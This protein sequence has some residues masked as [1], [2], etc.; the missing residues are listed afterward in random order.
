[1]STISGVIRQE[2]ICYAG[3]Y[4]RDY[5]RNR[6]V[7]AALRAAG[8]R[9]EEVHAPVFERQRDK[10]RPGPFALAAVLARLVL[11]Y[12]RLVPRTAWRLRRCNA[13]MVGYIGQS[14]ML[15]LAPVA[16]LLRR[17]VIFNPLVTLTDTLVEDRERLAPGSRAAR[18]LAALDRVALRLA[19]LVLTD[20]EENRAYLLERFGLAPARVV[21]V[22]VGADEA[23][24][25]PGAAGCAPGPLDVLFFG[26]FIPLHG[27]ETIVRAV[28]LLET[29]G[30]ALRVEF[31]GTGQTW[32]QTRA[33]ADDL[34]VRAIDWTDWL[35]EPLLADRLRQA[36]VALG[37][38]S[39][40]AKAGRVVPNKVYAALACGVATV[41]RD[42][43]AA[44]ALVRDGESALLVPPDDPAAL[45]CALARLTDSA[46]RARLAAG[47]RAAFERHASLAALTQ[48][49]EPVL[50]VVSH[51]D[52]P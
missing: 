5:P 20:T 50:V 22:P 48:A 6:V 33:L 42:S 2:R 17:P 8:A 10:S 45:A 28:A 12:C 9:V 40:G 39:G 38:F 35:P 23:L 1:M 34:G 36:D 27:I 47:G 51:P 25:Y 52:R 15:V 31:V 37:I 29:Q 32:A 4:E 14:D 13:L 18:L 43:P 30:V 24:Y 46:L 11:A 3:T 21:V 7:I 44:R 16:R 49:V 26:K 19:D 41:T